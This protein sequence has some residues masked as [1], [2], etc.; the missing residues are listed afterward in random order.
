[1]VAVLGVDLVPGPSEKAE[2]V[3]SAEVHEGDFDGAGALE[4]ATGV[5]KED[6]SDEIL[7]TRFRRRVDAEPIEF[8]RRFDTGPSYSD[9]AAG[10]G[11][12]RRVNGDRNARG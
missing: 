10:A 4:P 7:V 5:S 11:E 3:I 12:G 1:M 9:D 8:R 6:V 2:D